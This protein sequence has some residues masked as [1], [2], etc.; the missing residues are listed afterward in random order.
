MAEH[1]SVI[2]TGQKLLLFR[3]CFTGLVNCYGTYDLVTGRAFQVK[4]PVTDQVLLRHLRGTQPYGVYLLVGDK[5][6]A[7]V[8]D[9]DEEDIQ[10]P[11][12]FMR[13]ASSC[14]IAM[15]LERSRRRGWH[16]WGFF[17]PP[18]VLA[19]KAR[20]VAK[21]I[22]AEIGSPKT[23]VFPKQDR[24]AGQMQFGNYIYAGLFGRLVSKGRTVFVDPDADCRPFTDQWQV[25]ASVHR[26][27]ESV[28][29]GFLERKDGGGKSTTPDAAR[30]AARPSGTPPRTF[31]LP[32]CAQR[33][34]SA[35]VVANQRVSCFHLALQL[36][37]AGLP[38]ELAV[39]CLLAWALK[40][41]PSDGNGVITNAE[42]VGQTR[43]A[44]SRNYRGCGC[45]QPAVMPYC[46][47]NCPVYG[48]RNG[49]SQAT[50]AGAPPTG[51][52]CS[53]QPTKESEDDDRCFRQPSEQ[54]DRERPAQGTASA[55]LPAEG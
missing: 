15:Y 32:P 13:R 22:L 54:I 48:S 46:D 20:A 18:G 40:N 41:Q 34:L 52:S 23:E 33:M 8:A 30:T 43:S 2:T 9:F 21:L 29:D 36:K 28:L 10:P 45:E 27:S 25:L 44:Y 26:V 4:Q 42:I 7:V 53:A 49:N 19:S 35:G 5:T 12:A 1:G 17:Q 37:K 16:V 11:L 24:L 55:T 47:S 38:Y 14:G 39:P 50:A 6:R 3:S 51:P 31:G